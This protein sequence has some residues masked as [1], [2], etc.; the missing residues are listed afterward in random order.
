MG[1]QRQHLGQRQRST[2]SVDLEAALAL[3]LLVDR[4]VERHG[5]AVV[6]GETVQRRHVPHR[7]PGVEVLLVRLRERTGVLA[8]QP[9]DRTVAAE[10]VQRDVEVVLPGAGRLDDL[11]LEDLAVEVAD[12]LPLL[13]PHDEV[14]AGQHGLGHVGGVVHRLGADG[15]LEDL[16]HL[17]PDRG[18]VAVTRQVDQA[19]QV[20]VVHVAADE[21][22]DRAALLQ[23]QDGLHD[24]Q[25]VLHG[26]LEQL[27]ARVGL[28]HVQQALAAVAVRVEPGQAEQLDRLAA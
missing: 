9:V 15:V 23:V 1:Q 2:G 24:R 5:Q 22:L 21:Q 4:G 11:L 10:G 3:P 17:Q 14:H 8:A 7:D 6:G 13:H 25:Q 20:A 28:Q 16:L 12:R 19:G 18:R 27:V 26:R